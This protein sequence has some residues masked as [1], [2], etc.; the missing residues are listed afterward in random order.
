MVIGCEKGKGMG[1]RS[2][3]ALLYLIKFAPPPS[4]TMRPTAT[5]A[6][7]LTCSNEKPSES[8]TSRVE[9]MFLLLSSKVDSIVKAEGAPMADQEAWSEPVEGIGQSQSN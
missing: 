2:N 6:N 8:I 9:W 3:V 5:L 4:S 1:I 7:S